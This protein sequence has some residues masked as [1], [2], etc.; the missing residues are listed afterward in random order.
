MLE[1]ITATIIAILITFSITL[2][3]AV[4]THLKSNK[5]C[6][7]DFEFNPST[8]TNTF[9]IPTN[10]ISNQQNSTNIIKS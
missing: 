9:S 10:N 8:N 7:F 4:L 1:P 2:I 5:C 6:G 3:V